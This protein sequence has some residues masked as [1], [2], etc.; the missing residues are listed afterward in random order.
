[1]RVSQGFSQDL[2]GQMGR[3]CFLG[4]QRGAGEPVTD[5]QWG[6]RRE[7]PGES[8]GPAQGSVVHGPPPGGLQLGPRR[9]LLLQSSTRFC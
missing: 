1:M 9:G 5:A 3:R 7:E 6:A 2:L 4:V 8:S